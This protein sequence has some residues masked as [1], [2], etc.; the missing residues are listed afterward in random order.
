[1]CCLVMDIAHLRRAVTDKNGAMVERWLLP[2]R[3][4]SESPSYKDQP[5][6]V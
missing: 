5:A 3:Q 6:Y 2:P 4:H 1:M